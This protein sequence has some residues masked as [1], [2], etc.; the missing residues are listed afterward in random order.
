[1]ANANN[2]ITAPVRLSA[3]VAR[4]R[5]SASN[6]LGY[7]CANSDGKTNFYAKYKPVILATA[8]PNRNSDWWR[9]D[10]GRCGINLPA[11][12]IVVQSSS[13]DPLWGYN[14]P[15]GG[16]SQP[17]RQADWNNYDANA[18]HDWGVISAGGRVVKGGNSYTVAMNMTTPNQSSLTYAE[19][20]YPAHSEDRG[21]L[22]LAFYRANVTNPTVV[23]KR[24]DYDTATG[25]NTITLT[26]SELNSLGLTVG[27]RMCIHFF[28][29]V[30]DNPVS[31]RNHADTPT[32]WHA[33]VVGSYPYEYNLR[34]GW[35]LVRG[36][37]SPYY[38]YHVQATINAQSGQG[39]TLAAGTYLK[40][41]K[42]IAGTSDSQ[43]NSLYSPLW[44]SGTLN[45]SAVSVAAGSATNVG[46]QYDE[47]VYT[48]GV[49]SITI[50]W[51]A[52]NGNVLAS[53]RISVQQAATAPF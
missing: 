28:G 20:V 18:S 47:V 12:S 35:L 10:D 38:L 44:Q 48:E 29:R 27:G 42:T 21:G 2:I 17:L 13:D 50:I 45:S 39:G 34:G 36:T 41:Y 8:F 7:Q 5:N 31:L 37:S 43:Y 33:T 22:W 6:A 49:N 24:A 16:S 26:Q 52:S 46:R 15:Q 23:E 51:Y 11:T 32:V 25:K 53:D 4:V 14:A 30:G 3:D 40:A 19:V 1:M 9:G